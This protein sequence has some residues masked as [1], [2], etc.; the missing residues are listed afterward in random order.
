MITYYVD[1]LKWD[2]AIETLLKIW[3]ADG[4]LKTHEELIE[5][6]EELTDNDY[7]EGTEEDP[8]EVDIMQSIF[9]KK[10]FIYT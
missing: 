7:I 5:D 3:K 10:K 8:Y 6:T 2:R 4:L 1:D 9:E